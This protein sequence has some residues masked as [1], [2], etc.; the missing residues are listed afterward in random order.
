MVTVGALREFTDQGYV[1]V[2]AT[3]RSTRTAVA[4]HVAGDSVLRWPRGP[5]WEGKVGAGSPPQ[6]RH[7]TVTGVRLFFFDAVMHRARAVVQQAPRERLPP[8]PRWERGRGGNGARARLPTTQ[9]MPVSR[10]RLVSRSASLQARTL[11]VTSPPR[12]FV[13]LLNALT[14]AKYRAA[15]R[16][17]GCR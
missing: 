3:V 4:A 8:M 16:Y 2:E 10:A 15:L 12:S 7:R 14:C 17:S 6:A 13:S 1:R 11:T 9:P 5:A